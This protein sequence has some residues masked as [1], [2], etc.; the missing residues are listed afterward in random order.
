MEA[1]LHWEF[2]DFCESYQIGHVT[3]ALFYLQSNGLAER[4]VATLKIAL[5]KVRASPT[6]KALQ[7]FLQVYRITPNNKTPAS[8]TPAKVMFACRIQSVYDIL[9]P[10]QMK[11]GRTNT[12]PTKRYNPGEK[13]FQNF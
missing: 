5:K 8:Q 7:Q 2:K 13:V 1:S 6:K 10:K 9:L 11:L 3:T 4:F 12:V